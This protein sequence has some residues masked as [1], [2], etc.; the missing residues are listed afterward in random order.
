MDGRDDKYNEPNNE[1]PNSGHTATRGKGK[2]LPEVVMKN[3]LEK[4]SEER[5]CNMTS[6]QRLKRVFNIDICDHCGGQVKVIT[7]IEDPGIIEHIIKHLK[8][9]D[10]LTI[11]AYPHTL[12]PER[13]PP[14]W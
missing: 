7:S 13:S 10:V 2:T 5:H 8:Q 11:T 4:T 1:A 3:W 6:M 14:K 12:P 9:K